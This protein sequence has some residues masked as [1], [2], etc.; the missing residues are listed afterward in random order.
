MILITT[1]PIA[2][3]ASTTVHKAV[4]PGASLPAWAV[5]ATPLATLSISAGAI[6]APIPAAAV[7]PALPAVA[8]EPRLRRF[9]SLRRLGSF[10]RAWRLAPV[11]PAAGFA[12]FALGAH[13]A[14]FGTAAAV[15]AAF[16]ALG[17]VVAAAALRQRRGRLGRQY[18]GDRRHHH[19]L[20]RT[21][22]NWA[23]HAALQSH[24]QVR[25]AP[26]G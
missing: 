4:T 15:R 12:D 10:A 18:D 23:T 20:H 2:A 5:A 16:T 7:T 24:L 21:S 8:P 26:T 22:P 19:S 1:A 14:A 6:P 11:A 3:I 13:A 25:C 17:P 9:G